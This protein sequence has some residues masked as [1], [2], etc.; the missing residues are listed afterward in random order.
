MAKR[1]KLVADWHEINPATMKPAVQK[2]YVAYKAHY[3]AGK[4]L[5]AAFEKAAIDA[6]E[7]A[8]TGTTLAFGYNFGKLSMAV[9]PE[10]DKAVSKKAIDF[11]SLTA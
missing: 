2:A 9:V 5:K 8:G 7:L 1:E 4:A 11:A 6:M 10:R 3:A